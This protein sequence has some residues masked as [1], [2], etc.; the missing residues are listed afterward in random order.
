[1]SSSLSYKKRRTEVSVKLPQH[2]LVCFFCN[3][4]QRKAEPVETG[5]AGVTKP[6]EPLLCAKP[7]GGPS[8]SV[9]YYIINSR[10]CKNTVICF[11]CKF[12]RICYL[13][14]PFGCVSCRFR[15][16]NFCVRNKCAVLRLFAKK[17]ENANF[18]RK[19]SFLQLRE[20]GAAV[21]FLSNMRQKMRGRTAKSGKSGDAVFA[22]KGGGVRRRKAGVARLRYVACAKRKAGVLRCAVYAY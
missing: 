18:C 10:N 3:N 12:P 14:W 8:F 17:L 16:K 7:F 20:R 9:N 15:R 1:M 13:F 21:Q 22:E 11:I 4:P 19:G 5:S 6:S 2:Y